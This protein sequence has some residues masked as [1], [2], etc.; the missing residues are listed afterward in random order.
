MH[1]QA[2]Q[3]RQKQ[4]NWFARHKVLT[5]AG[6]LV[7]VVGIGAAVAPGGSDGE[8]GGSKASD[9]VVT[10]SDAGGA[11]Q[12]GKSGGGKEGKSRKAGLSGNGTFRVGSDVKPGTYRSVGNKE[13]DNCYWERAKDSKGDPDSII[14]NDNVIG[15]S[16]VTIATGDKVF[17]THGCKGWERVPEKKSGTPRTSAPGNG[18]YRVGVDIPPGTYTSADN[19]ADGNCYWERAKDAL[20]GIDSIEANENVTGNGLVTITPQD[21]YFKT[22]GCTTWKKTG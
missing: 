10:S 18:M 2:Q 4:R 6:A 22:S 11:A 17:K 16:Y 1:Q 12:G 7:L 5:G 8:D 20:H 9:R 3:H 21:A 15:S 13:D 14:A 19:K